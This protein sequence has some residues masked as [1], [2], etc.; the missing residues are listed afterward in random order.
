LGILGVKRFI[1]IF[2]RS[3]SSLKNAAT[4][5]AYVAPTV[6]DGNE[7]QKVRVDKEVD[8][9]RPQQSSLIRSRICAVDTIV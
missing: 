2:L 1:E 6:G 8:N 4:S 9:S 3:F 5:M 7:L